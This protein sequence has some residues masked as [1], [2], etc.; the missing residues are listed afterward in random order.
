MN[1]NLLR[2]AKTLT[3]SLAALILLVV[4]L[5][6]LLR[7]DM[8]KRYLLNIGVNRA[9]NMLNGTLAVG[10]ISG[11][12]FGQLELTDISLIREQDTV[13][14]IER[15]KLG[16]QLSPLWD[17]QILIDSVIIDSVAFSLRQ[18]PDSI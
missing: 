15:V 2:V 9:N 16:Y 12:V 6:L 1:K 17:G 7:T 18:N 4:I 11:P 3:Y 5:L 14:R 13:C 8:M 10:G